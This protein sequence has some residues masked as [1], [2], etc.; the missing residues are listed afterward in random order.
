MP[1]T[2]LWLPCPKTPMNARQNAALKVAICVIR[3]LE[4]VI[5][6]ETSKEEG[7]QNAYS[8]VQAQGTYVQPLDA[9]KLTIPV[10]GA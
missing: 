3:L 6:V 7:L 9:L 2:L 10:V 8:V 1:Q 5:A 4:L